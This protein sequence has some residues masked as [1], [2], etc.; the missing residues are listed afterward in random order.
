MSA[1]SFFPQYQRALSEQVPVNFEE[2]FAPLSM[3][4]DLSI[5]PS[6]KG[7]SVYFKDITERKLADQ[8]IM[9]ANQRY[10]MV[11]RATND[12]IYEWNITAKTVYWNEGYETLFGHKR[13]GDKM[14]A[15]SWIENLHP[16]EKD[17]LL[18][19]T[20]DAFK[21]KLTSLT[22]ELQFRCADGSYKIVF[23]N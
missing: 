10:E 19:D 7:L 20:D 11:A 3:W 17:K 2:F 4:V 16:D 21:K 9:A 22:R 12:A 6:E 15:A 1:L 14:S 8:K 23:D 13:A 18:A 5:Y